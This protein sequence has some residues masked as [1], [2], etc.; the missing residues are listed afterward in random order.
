MVTFLVINTSNLQI[1]PASVI[2]IR[3]AAGSSNPAEIIGTVIVASALTMV[4]AIITVKLMAKLP[5]YR[6]Q[7]LPTEES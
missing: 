5:G 3:A 2:A 1:I 6:K 7:L 4:I